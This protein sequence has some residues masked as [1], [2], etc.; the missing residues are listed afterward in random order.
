[1]KRLKKLF[2]LAPVDRSE[3][4]REARGRGIEALGFTLLDQRG[5]VEGN[6]APRRY[7]L[8]KDGQTVAGPFS[9][10]ADTLEAARRLADVPSTEQASEA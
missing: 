9:S 2:G 8:Q 1:M 7:F 6:Y 3:E 5:W 10:Y 4:R